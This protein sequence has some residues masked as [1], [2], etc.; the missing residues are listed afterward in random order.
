MLVWQNQVLL[1]ALGLSFV[2]TL[3]LSAAM[4]AVFFLM[5]R[6]LDRLAPGSKYGIYGVSLF[7]VFL[8]WIGSFGCLVFF[9][10][11]NLFWQELPGA[12]EIAP[13][14]AVVPVHS[15]PT[16]WHEALRPAFPLLALCW[17][18][19]VLVLSLRHFGG[20][21]AL[22]RLRSVGSTACCAAWCERAAALAGK[23][24]I[25]GSV[26]LRVSSR[27]ESPFTFGVWR[28]CILLPATAFTGLSV[29]QLEALLAHELAHIRRHDYLVNLF[30][31]CVETLLF[32]N[33]LVWWLSARVRAA[34]EQCC[35]DMA[36]QVLG[37][38][39]LYARALVS[40]AE[41]RASLPHPALGATGG[42]T[43]MNNNRFGFRVRRI[44]GLTA[45][46]N[47]LPLAAC[48]AA[49]CTAIV[50]LA[51]LWPLP[52]RGVSHA[53]DGQEHKTQRF[54]IRIRE[55]NNERDIALTLND[56]QELTKDSPVTIN[57]KQARFSD[58]TPM[59]QQQMRARLAAAREEFRKGGLDGNTSRTI[60]RQEIR[61]NL[62]G[63][64]IELATRTPAADTPVTV[65][66]K[67]KRFGDLDPALQQKI[68]DILSQHVAEGR[69][70]QDSDVRRAKEETRVAINAGKE[71]YVVH[72][73]VLASDTPITVA[74]KTCKFRELS[75][76]RR[77]RLRKAW[78]QSRRSRVA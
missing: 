18:L 11:G 45:P 32:Y 5:R 6:W 7:W 41:W 1:T 15:G 25:R 61:L 59:E 23:F 20:H 39:I 78:E 19:G 69:S 48:M 24:G 28:A 56:N 50:G 9:E 29:A 12:N 70:S 60:V 75:S 16:A 10:N 22:Q 27:I 3:A 49:C 8:L 30:Q 37:D 33:P 65:D 47:R 38:R 46:E 68:R 52:A 36:V 72:G 34:R 21:L 64:E 17:T 4:G 58:L 2:Y 76:A 54:T 42:D 51:V 62:N 73:A 55:S 14:R 31:I 74:G 71:L 53:G 63:I 13:G 44:L 40:L 26:A 57:G 35:D 43:N 66:G 67:S 77:T